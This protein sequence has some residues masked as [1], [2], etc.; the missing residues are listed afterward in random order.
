MT[1]SPSAAQ[2]RHYEIVARAIDFIRCNTRRQPTLAE[3]A[4]E[5]HLSEQ[6]LQ[7]VFTA[8]A[9][10]SP[11]RFLQYLTKEHA[12]LALRQ[13]G[14]L[15]SVA[16]ESGLSGPGRLH[17]LM[18][19]CEAMTP[20]E[21]KA[22]GRGV[23]VTC[24]VAPTPFGDTL[25]GWTSRGLCYLAF[26][27]GDG[28]VKQGELSSQWPRATLIRDD[29]E[30]SRLAERIFPTRP[31][32]GKLHLLLRGSNF[33]LKVWEALINT[34]PSQLL[35]YS[36]LASM[37]DAPRAQRAVGSAVAANTIG[38]LIPCHRVIR[39]SGESG[40]YRW[41]ENRKMAIQAWEARRL[42][43]TR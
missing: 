26:C 7:R 22:L 35:S 38:Y 18:V 31:A 5:V 14:D 4:G 16:L 32:P 28:S 8:W 41:G 40:I 1:E 2:R 11:K 19:T 33:Q 29:L 27:D 43:T 21:I 30:A 6:R 13:S 12:K 17:D 34:R 23:T 3:I 15:L 10:V 42:D 25:I 39:E 20:G 37:V 36:Q 24:G 9:G